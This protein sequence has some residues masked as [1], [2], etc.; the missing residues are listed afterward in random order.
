MKMS[1]ETELRKELKDR[2]TGR[3]EYEVIDCCYSGKDGDLEPSG[4]QG[5]SLVECTDTHAILV[6]HLYASLVGNDVCINFREQQEGE[7]DEEHWEA[8][9]KARD[10]YLS[11]AQQ[12]VCEIPARVEWDGGDWAVSM[13]EKF[14]VGLVFKGDGTFDPEATADAVEEG[15]DKVVAP[16]VLELSGV[17]DTLDQ[18][19]GWKDGE[20]N[21]IKDGDPCLLAAWS[22]HLSHEFVEG[23]GFVVADDDKKE[24][25]KTFN[26]E[27]EATA[28]CEKYGAQS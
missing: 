6:G 26:T 1:Y 17:H 19:S 4:D 15:Y 21:S 9:E 5:V 13:D 7:S 18:L 8:Y 23:V 10:S 2:S 20:G 14:R 27:E 25:V 16:L 28:Y 3:W 24:Y 12:V 11:Y 22:P